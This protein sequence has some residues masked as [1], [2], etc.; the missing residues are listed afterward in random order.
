MSLELDVKSAKGYIPNTPLRHYESTSGFAPYLWYGDDAVAATA[1]WNG[2]PLGSIYV[3]KASESA[4]PVTYQKVAAD[5]AVTDWAILQPSHGASVNVKKI[6]VSVLTSGEKDTGW[7]L[8][9]KAI[10]LN[11]WVDVVTPE[12]TSGTKTIDVGLLSGES[13][14]DADGFLD[15]VS[16]A[17]AGIKQ[18]TMTFADGSSQNYVSASTVGLLLYDGLLGADGAGTAGTVWPTPHVASSVTAKSV[19]YTLGDAHTELVAN[20]YIHYVLLGA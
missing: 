15:G 4:T 8:P 3:Y 13:G 5:G 17:T 6:P 18:G 12:A 10:V 9:A 2:A 11:V 20:I 16:T 19:S 1:L 14:G 7:D